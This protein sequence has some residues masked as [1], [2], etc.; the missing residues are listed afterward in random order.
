MVD[1][2]RHTTTKGGVSEPEN[3][4]FPVAVLRKKSL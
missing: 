2:V 4:I 3:R 1:I